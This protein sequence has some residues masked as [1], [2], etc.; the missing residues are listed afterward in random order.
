MN[1]KHIY[2]ELLSHLWPRFE[3]QREA[4]MKNRAAPR[5]MLEKV[6]MKRVLEPIQNLMEENHSHDGIT[7]RS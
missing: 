5:S 2:I 6:A 1:Q 7:D 3:D 4:S